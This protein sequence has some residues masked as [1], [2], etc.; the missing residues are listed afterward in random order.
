[1]RHGNAA[2]V[3]G[4]VKAMIKDM[5]DKLLEEAEEDATKK[6]Y[7]DKE[8]SE[9]QKKQDDKE[10]TIEK[11]TTKIDVMTANSKKLKGEVATLQKELADL[12]RTQA[13]MDKLRA[14]E[15][16]Q[17]ETNKPEMEMGLA[18]VKAALKVLREYYSKDEAKAHEQAEGAG[19]GIIGMLE[20]CESD[21]SKGLAEMV[22][23][24]EAASR[25]YDETTKENNIVKATKEQDSKYK[26]Q[27]YV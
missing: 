13:E 14:E 10:D 16:A 21:F 19:S 9:T 18:G 5:I 11:M 17:F 24:E 3:F 25:K 6:A 8:M 23:A 1:M 15:K 22:A 27:E 4:K 2:D 20:V 26:K 7:C 12:S